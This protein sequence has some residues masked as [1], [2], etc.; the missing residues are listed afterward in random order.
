MLVALLD[1]MRVDAWTSTKGPRYLCPRCGLE[2][3]LKQGR[4]VVH[5][6]A[7]KPPVSCPWGGGETYD[8]MAAKMRLAEAL[9]QLG[10]IAELEKEVLSVA[11]DRRAD[12]L[13][14]NPSGAKAAF[15]IQH[16]PISYEALEVRTR[17]YVAAG[18]PMIWIG[19]TT[20]KMKAEIE[21]DSDGS[22]ID[23][24]SPSAWE[25][26]VHAL[27]FKV[28]WYC[29]PETG[30]L[31]KGSLEPYSIEVPTSS[32]HNEYGEE[33]SA[34]GFSRNS[35]R[36]KYLRLDGPFKV[37]DLRI[38]TRKR[39]EWAVGPYN[40]PAGRFLRFDQAHI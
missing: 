7:H 30:E 10:Y 17:A 36:W 25:K 31:W 1:G 22:W 6:F 11:G 26:W 38:T 19:I 39:D 15:E 14:T 23:R 12:I 34:G 24:Y 5:H 8:H 13:A 20:S 21:G 37:Q 2:V 3:I 40:L 32:W 18:I 16:T 29:D 28:I 27:G 35:K 4:I 33:Q 9:R